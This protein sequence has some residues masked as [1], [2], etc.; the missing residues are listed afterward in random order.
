VSLA[1]AFPAPQSGGP[2]RSL[3]KQIPVL[4]VFSTFI[5]NTC[6][7]NQAEFPLCLKDEKAKAPS[8][9]NLKYMNSGRA[10]IMGI[11]LLLT[12]V[13]PTSAQED[14]AGYKFTGFQL[15][16]GSGLYNYDYQPDQAELLSLAEN[17]RFL[18]RDLTDFTKQPG[19]YYQGPTFTGMAGGKVY[20]RKKG[21]KFRHEIFAGIRYSEAFIS[22]TSYSRQEHDT[23]S[24]F[25]D[26]S[27]NADR[28]LVHST[29]ESYQFNIMAKRLILP[30]GLSIFSKR[31]R[32]IWLSA[33]IGLAPF[34]SFDHR[35]RGMYNFR[36]IEQVTQPGKEL[37]YFGNVLG[38]ASDRK[39]HKL[40]SLGGG[41][42]LGIP[43]ALHLHAPPGLRVLRNF[44]PFVSLMPLFLY[45]DT[46]IGKPVSGFLMN[47][48][49]GI[50]FTNL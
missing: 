19:Y 15:D 49:A 44:N 1:R 4:V 16:I 5:Y 17:D 28:Y 9:M 42:Y 10:K 29:H 27:L 36:I 34:L 39:T 46:R 13:R 40:N 18:K 8:R 41:F 26:P 22:S 50:R 23:I 31:S 12:A 45:S 2:V 21:L 47:A 14:S 20:F 43:L 38:S 33:G 6:T 11:L 30:L 35:L 32:M 25:F 3:K 7:L 37:S 24:S 48:S